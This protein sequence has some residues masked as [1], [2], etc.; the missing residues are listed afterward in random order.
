MTE[1]FRNLCVVQACRNPGMLDPIIKYLQTISP[2]CPNSLQI[3]GNFLQICL[4]DGINCKFHHSGIPVGLV[5]NAKLY[6]NEDQTQTQA[7]DDLDQARE[8]LKKLLDFIK[9]LRKVNIMENISQFYLTH[10]VRFLFWKILEIHNWIRNIFGQHS[11]L[12]FRSFV[13]L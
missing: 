8:K 7:L 9:A 4:M 10:I 5:Q 12:S 6:K 3:L 1:V 13:L 2:K 11:N